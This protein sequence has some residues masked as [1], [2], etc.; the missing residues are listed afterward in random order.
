MFSLTPWT[1]SDQREAGARLLLVFCVLTP[2]AT[3]HSLQLISAN[4][5]ILCARACGWVGYAMAFSWTRWYGIVYITWISTVFSNPDR[6][7][8]SIASAIVDLTHQRQQPTTLPPPSLS[9]K[10]HFPT[11]T[12]LIAVL[13]AAATPCLAASCTGY[14]TTPSNIAACADQLT[15]RGSELCKVTSG[16]TTTFCEIGDAMIVG[17]GVG[18]PSGV[19]TSSPW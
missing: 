7:P 19:E 11:T 15:A 17:V 5:S 10:M 12:T 4:F 1:T 8:R 9:P 2:H 6:S 13:A 16:F 3:A 18:T 14:Q